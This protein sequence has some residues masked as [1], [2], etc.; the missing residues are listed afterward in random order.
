MSDTRT[1]LDSYQPVAQQPD[2]PCLT[3]LLATN[4]AERKRRQLFPHPHDEEQMLLMRQ[5]IA[6]RQA[7]GLLGAMLGVLPPAAIFQK[8]FGYGFG[9]PSSRDS[10]L[11]ILLCLAMNVVCGIVGWRMG[12]RL[13]LRI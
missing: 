2:A 11:V 10:L 1:V 5:P 9:G 12:R 6:L 4:A 13:S 8:I 7:Y 3:A